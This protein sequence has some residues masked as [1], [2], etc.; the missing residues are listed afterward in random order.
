MLFW[1]ITL[2]PILC[3]I[4]LLSLDCMSQHIDTKEQEQEVP[5]DLLF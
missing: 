4:L 3:V 1:I 2:T 5:N